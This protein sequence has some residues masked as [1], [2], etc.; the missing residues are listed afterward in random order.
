MRRLLAL[1]AVV[2]AVHGF[3]THLNTDHVHDQDYPSDNAEQA[4]APAARETAIS[5][6]ELEVSADANDLRMNELQGA[7]D[8]LQADVAD[9]SSESVNMTPQLYYMRSLKGNGCGDDQFQCLQA[10][11]EVPQCI[12]NMA[13]CD[14]V[15][16]CKNGNDE[17]PSICKNHTPAGSSWGG[18]LEWVGCAAHRSKRVYIVIT[19]TWQKSY[20]PSIQMV[21]AT[22]V[23]SWVEDGKTM[24]NTEQVEGHYCYGAHALKLRAANGHVGADITCNFTDD[25]HCHGKI[26]KAATGTL[27]SRVILTR[28]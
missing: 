7:L 15:Q 12:A 20:M 23:F 21:A 11:D 16:D 28:Q 1:L 4:P 18:D 22:L 8:E 10:S 25:N 17:I 9:L 14:G 27:C 24:T 26:Y 6:I 3:S 5:S 2:A 19:R 13:V